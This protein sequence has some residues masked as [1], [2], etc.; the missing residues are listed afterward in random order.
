MGRQEQPLD[1]GQGPLAAFAHGLRELRRE[2]GSPPY[3]RLAAHAHYSAS[4]LAAAASGQRLPSAAVLAAFVTACGGDP[5][6]WE[7]RRLDTHRALMADAVGDGEPEGDGPA[8]SGDAAAPA[9]PP[10]PEV[11]VRAARREAGQ[12]AVRLLAVA[13]AVVSLAAL[14]PGD[15]AAR[16]AGHERQESRSRN[17][18]RWLRPGSGV[19][20][21]YR[22]LIIEAG[23]RCDVPEVTPA[24][25]AAILDAE[26]GF[27]PDLSDPAEDE[28]GIARWT[29]RVLR[30][31]LPPDRQATVP[32]PPFS[33]EDSIP[34]VGRMLCAIAPLVEGVPGDPSLNLAASYRASTWV[35]QRQDPAELRSLQPYLD[36]VRA[37]LERYGC[38]SSSAPGTPR[39]GSTPR[40]AGCPGR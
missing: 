25:I 18:A 36:R 6:E 37:G 4:T 34:A 21:R 32:V 7:R 29:P 20:D 27:D 10:A 28:Y 9:P 2:A 23:T 35:V 12:Q 16:K 5:E 38:V 30:Y 22:P 3:R 40:E 26:S 8:A 19:P 39:A 14:V 31:Y 33:P 17:D 11:P 1:P 24:L 15:V 13:A